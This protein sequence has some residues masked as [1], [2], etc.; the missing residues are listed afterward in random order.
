MTSPKEIPTK[1]TPA[2]CVV[3]K[4]VLDKHGIT[5]LPYLPAFD[6]CL[7]FQI[8]EVDTGGKYGDTGIYMPEAVRSNVERGACRGVLLA[9][10][11]NALDHLRSHNVEVG[12]TV[13]FS[14]LA[15]WRHGVGWKDGKEL[16]MMFLRSA[17][18]AGSEE[19]MAR[20]QAGQAEVQYNHK[21]GEHE[22]LRGGVPVNRRDTPV[23]EY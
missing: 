8:P 13:W 15:P 12:D 3:G 20:L 19:A 22:W 10:G 1:R 21:L 5:K 9:A 4:D 11:A 18:I 16:E 14:K 6:R 7:V 2:N 23:D 17:D